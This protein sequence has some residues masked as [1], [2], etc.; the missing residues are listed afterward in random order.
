MKYW[1]NLIAVLLTLP[2]FASTSTVTTHHHRRAHTSAS[3]QDPKAA[4]THLAKLQHSRR[5]V[6]TGRSAHLRRTHYTHRH[7]YYER[8]T[9][10]SFADGDLT[11]GDIVTGED[12]VVRQAAIDA[13]GNMN[14]TAVA[15]DPSNGRILAMVNQ[16]LALSSGA[17]PCST[18]KL[19]VALA[20]L[21]EGIVTKDTPVNLGGHYHMNMTEALAH[22]NNL[23][24]ETLGRR[25]GF[26]RVRHYANE[27]GL[28][29]L[30]GYNIPGE[31]LG[32]YP[33]QVLPA[34]EG[35]VGRMCSFGEGVSM[36]PLQLGAIVAA[37]ANGGTLYY[38]QH[39]TTPQEV[40][41][42][43]PR[44]KRTLDIGKLI[45]EI[46]DG[47]HAAVEYGT[48]RSLKANFN[49]FPVMGKTGTCSNNG[50]RF[51]WFASYADTQYGRIVTVFFLE[52]GRPTFGPK[53]AELTGYFYRNLWDHSYF[54][55]KQTTDVPTASAPMP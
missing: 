44:I 32:V 38:L 21:E 40:A 51:G 16:K 48:A 47:M 55:E 46:S 22:S 13:L 49:Q 36:T 45:P 19:S 42:F 4:H 27:F 33:S 8:F 20:A 26:E 24:F 14:G 39:P 18:I 10:N 7:R 52:G 41:N 54:A 53:A 1:I 5:V 31:Q 17:E 34:S 28:G 50:T 35:G 23:Y 2:V 6:R 43:Q 15:I 3:V 37:I 25:L 30:A 9:G 11:S 29:E 12:P